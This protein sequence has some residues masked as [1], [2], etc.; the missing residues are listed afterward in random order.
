MIDDTI[1]PNK[2]PHDYGT[3]TEY[4]NTSVNKWRSNNSVLLKDGNQQRQ[5]SDRL[6]EDSLRLCADRY[7]MNNLAETQVKQKIGL[8]FS[9][10]PFINIMS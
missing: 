10:R 8:Q 9:V 4:K 7:E 3:P 5:R 2:Y 6:V 1:S